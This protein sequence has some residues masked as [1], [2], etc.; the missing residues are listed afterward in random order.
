[1]ANADQTPLLGLPN[2]PGARGQSPRNA[3]LAPGPAIVHHRTM[4]WTIPNLL[5]MFRILAAP[6]LALAFLV[7][8]RPAAD[9]VAFGLFAA[10]S[11]TDFFDGWLARRMGKITEIGKMLDPVA[12]K[13][14]VIVALAALMGLYASGPPVSDLRPY[15]YPSFVL[16]IP[17]TV[18]IL[19][20]VLVS[21][22]REY[23]GDVKIRVSRLAKWKTTIQMFAIGLL[24][25]AVPLRS[26]GRRLGLTDGPIGEHLATVPAVIMIV[27]AMALWLAAILTA[28]TGW[29]YF[30]KGLAYIRAKEES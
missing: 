26:S 10:A 18:I 6:G 20:E 9:W 30:R 12:D 19:R 13:A 21:G 3:A 7:F 15:S 11:I 4:R 24:L 14:M 29:D 8:D 27:G 28:I 23:L 16:V 5:T 17:V 2:I 25:L 22:L 1:M